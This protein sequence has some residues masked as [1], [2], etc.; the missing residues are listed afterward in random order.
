MFYIVLSNLSILIKHKVR[1]RQSTVCISLSFVV[2]FFIL[3]FFIVFP[4]NIFNGIFTFVG[5][6]KHKYQYLFRSSLRLVSCY[7]NIELVVLV[8]YNLIYQ[9]KWI[10]IL[11]H[12]ISVTNLRLVCL[13][14][15]VA[16]IYIKLSFWPTCWEIWKF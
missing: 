3:I 5:G 12:F 2:I 16:Y 7:R 6:E 8:Q 9:W 13:I 1:S 11:S 10:R 4:I 14:P 15:I